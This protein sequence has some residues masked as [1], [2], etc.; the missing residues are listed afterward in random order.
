M[1]GS[2][3]RKGQ[4]GWRFILR[5]NGKELCGPIR[6]ERDRAD[7]D[8]A[9]VNKGKNP[10]RRFC[11]LKKEAAAEIDDVDAELDANKAR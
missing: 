9:Y 10:T 2:V 8:K 4:R 11:I 3:K 7:A 6:R 1:L 5:I